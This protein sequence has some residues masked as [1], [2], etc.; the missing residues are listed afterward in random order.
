MTADSR[1]CDL[2]RDAPAGRWRE[3]TGW[4]RPRDDGG[5]NAVTLRR[6]TGR[7]ACDACIAKLRAGASI[8][9]GTL[10]L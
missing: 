7:V 3:I 5:T 4:D 9:Q 6:E 10:G 1:H 8:G 2:C